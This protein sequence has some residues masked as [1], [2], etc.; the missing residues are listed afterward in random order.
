MIEEI[1]AKAAKIKTEPQEDGTK[2]A[3][4]P[5]GKWKV[6]PVRDL[7]KKDEKKMTSVKEKP[8][9]AGPAKPTGK[10]EDDK[11]AKDKDKA[12]KTKPEKKKRST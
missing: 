3:G 5:A 4:A 6:T 1:N 8:A 9:K 2:N 12:T 11:E 10:D 7:A